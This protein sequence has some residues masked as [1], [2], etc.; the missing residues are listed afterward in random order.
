[1]PPEDIKTTLKAIGGASVHL[2]AADGQ[3]ITL[4]A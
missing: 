1:M 2:T 4:Q 3:R